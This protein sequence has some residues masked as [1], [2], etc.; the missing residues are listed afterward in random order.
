MSVSVPQVNFGDHNALVEI[1]QDSMAILGFY[2][3]GDNGS[4]GTLTAD[5]VTSFQ[6]VN[7]IT[8]PNPSHCGDLTWQALFAALENTAT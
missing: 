6:E 8:V 4:Y 3:G 2:G 1:L 7:D 5:A